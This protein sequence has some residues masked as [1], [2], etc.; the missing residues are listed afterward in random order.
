MEM[1]NH[2]RTLL[3]NS[4]SAS[5]PYAAGEEYVP[6]DFVPA[7]LPQYLQDVRSTLFGENAD[8]ASLN[9]QLARLLSCLHASP[10]M[11]D[12]T[13]D[14]P[15]I[16]YNPTEPAYDADPEAT[17]HNMFSVASAEGADLSGVFRR[18]R[19]AAETRWTDWWLDSSAPAT[20][21]VGA[22]AL[23]LASRTKDVIDGTYDG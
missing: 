23:A 12:L 4:P 17:S 15:R 18:G 21:R 6:M 2:V 20:L 7:V 10:L 3:L 19:S 1:V 14:D 9:L 11:D 13:A 8:R 5:P 16:S 22:L